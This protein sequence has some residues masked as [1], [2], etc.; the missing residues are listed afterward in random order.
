MGIQDKTDLI[1]VTCWE[2]LNKIKAI[3][4]TGWWECI[5]YFNSYHD[6][7]SSSAGISTNGLAQSTASFAK[8]Q[9]VL[10]FL[11]FPI[12]TFWGAGNWWCEVSKKIGIDKVSILRDPSKNHH[13][14]HLHPQ[15]SHIFQLSNF[16]FFRF[17]R[18]LPRFPVVSILDFFW[19]FWS[20]F[21]WQYQV[22]ILNNTKR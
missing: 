9:P 22:S 2:Q 1:N 3:D 20:L 15:I 17:L 13:N 4:I 12:Q 16:K 8:F 19:H 5:Y 11:F 10:D 14:E 6:R 18:H 7:R 21:P